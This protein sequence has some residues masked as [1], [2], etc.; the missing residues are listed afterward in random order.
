MTKFTMAIKTAKKITVPAPGEPIAADSTKE[1]MTP[2]ASA[3]IHP[4]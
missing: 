3:A 1:P 2:A 4:K